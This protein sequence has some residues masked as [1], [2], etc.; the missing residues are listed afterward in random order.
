MLEVRQAW[1]EQLKAVIVDWVQEADCNGPH[2]SVVAFWED[3]I[4]YLSINMHRI[5]DC[6]NFISLHG[7]HG[8]ESLVDVENEHDNV[9]NVDKATDQML[10]PGVGL[11][12]VINH[13]HDQVSFEDSELFWIGNRIH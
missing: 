11:P 7:L 4:I 1:F 10:I 5:W 3:S 13:I 8:K 12:L 6:H 2:E 9:A